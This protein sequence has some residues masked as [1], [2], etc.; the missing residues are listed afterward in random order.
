[1]IEENSSVRLIDFVQEKF[2]K[3]IFSVFPDRFYEIIKNN[4]VN[5]RK[6]IR[7]KMIG[8]ILRLFH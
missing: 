3:C 4:V 8:S 2:D 1:M 6:N 5:T 7:R